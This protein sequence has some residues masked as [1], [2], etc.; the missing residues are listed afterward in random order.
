MIYRYIFLVLLSLPIAAFCQSPHRYLYN[1]ANE[2]I[3]YIDTQ[4]SLY[5]VSNRQQVAYLIA[6]DNQ[7]VLDVYSMEGQKLGYF[8][9][10][11]LY[12]THKQIA[13]H[14][15]GALD[16]IERANAADK[17]IQSVLM[18]LQFYGWVPMDKF[19]KGLER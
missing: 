17:G 9:M 3:A 13:A 7:E 14:L 1:Q 18:G 5:L 16:A 2:K 4:K 6:S 12:N 19:L 15:A 11:I 8:R 10:G